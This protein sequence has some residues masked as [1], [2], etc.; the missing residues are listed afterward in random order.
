[1]KRFIALIL[2][3]LLCLSVSACKTDDSASQQNVSSSECTEQEVR[4]LIE[5]NLDC[6]FLFYISP[7]TQGGGTD[8][9]GYTKADNSY[10]ATYKDFSDFVK[11][12]YTQEKSAYLL[13][14][15]PSEENP[16]YIEKN[17]LV[18][19]DLDAVTPVEYKINWDDSYT[20]EFTE[21]STTHCAFELTTTDFD[22]NE[23]VTNGSAAFE[24]GKWL[25]EDM[26]Y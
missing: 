7:L 15:Y 9:D 14:S 11:N 22:G 10:F 13:G 25:L 18:Y 26:V 20:V 1:M 24:N 3:L 2:S 12:T 17:D 6:Y 8:S 23:Y 4:M 19:V 5:H 16:L 21:N